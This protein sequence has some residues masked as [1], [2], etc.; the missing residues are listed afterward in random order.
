MPWLKLANLKFT[1]K[2]VK[3]VGAERRLAGSA[4]GRSIFSPSISA[5]QQVLDA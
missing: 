2:A 3:P 4:T 5:R 1:P